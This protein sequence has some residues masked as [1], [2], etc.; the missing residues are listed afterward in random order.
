MTIIKSLFCLKGRM[1]LH[2]CIV[3]TFLHIV[4]ILSCSF[5]YIKRQSRCRHRERER[6][7][8]G[9]QSPIGCKM[10]IREKLSSEVINLAALTA[11]IF[12]CQL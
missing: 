9:T 3:Q 6:G 12:L 5:L 11:P 10:K 1:N 2:S 4:A 7:R 8:E